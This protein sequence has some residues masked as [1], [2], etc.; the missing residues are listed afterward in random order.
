MPRGNVLSLPPSHSG[1][2]HPSGMASSRMGRRTPPR[3]LE[4]VPSSAWHPFR[5][6]ASQD[7]YTPQ[8]L[9]TRTRFPP[10]QI[11]VFLP[12][13]YMSISRGSSTSAAKSTVWALNG[14]AYA[15]WGAAVQLDDA[16]SSGLLSP[17]RKAPIASQIWLET[18]RLSSALN[19]HQCG[20]EA[21]QLH[22]ARYFLQLCVSTTPSH[23]WSRVV[24]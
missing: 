18:E 11:S 3:I 9:L 12:G 10:P 20:V 16:T 13:E 15:L 7:I 4:L 22:A 5:T 24:H 21:S 23:S 8:R 1:P 19:R 17:E 14:R 2:L 6:F